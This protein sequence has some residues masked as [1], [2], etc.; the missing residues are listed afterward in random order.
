MPVTNLTFERGVSY[1]NASW[2]PPSVMER[3]GFIIYYDIIAIFV[4]SLWWPDRDNHT[5]EK[6]IYR[7]T[8]TTAKLDGLRH[9]AIYD[10]WISPVTSGGMGPSS[11]AQEITMEFGR[12]KNTFRIFI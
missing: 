11:N 4:P 6:H 2:F 12:F 10:I 7:S 9:H 1:I 5:E 8:T 3:R